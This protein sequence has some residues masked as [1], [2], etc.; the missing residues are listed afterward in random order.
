MTDTIIS[1]IAEQLGIAVDQAGQ[2]I[3][4]Y[5]PDYASLMIIKGYAPIIIFTV[6]FLITFIGSMASLVA[7]AHERR[8]RE[9]KLIR[10]YCDE[11]T[12]FF[13]FA[14]FL[15]MTIFFLAMLLLSAN[16]EVPK[17]IG[18]SEYP[19]A[20]LIDMALSKIGGM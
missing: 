18:W 14:V 4:T 13:V 16:F 7:F 2:F 3:T 1:E 17:I 12:S 19:E 6:L 20:M 15:V 9:V 11:Y 5:L 8:K 10:S